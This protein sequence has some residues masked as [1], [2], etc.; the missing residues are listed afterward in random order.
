M[1]TLRIKTSSPFLQGHN[2]VFWMAL[3][4]LLLRLSYVLVVEPSPSF[5]GGDA[6]WYMMNGRDLVTTGKTAGPL[7]TGPVY[8]VFVGM[9]QVLVPGQSSSDLREYTH[10]E[11]QTAR[12]FQSFLSAALCVFAYV[13]ARRAVGQR[14]ARLAAGILVISPAL[15][16]DAG[17]LTTEA[18]FMFL[19]FGGLAC[20]AG[21]TVTPRRLA[22]AGLI[23]GLASLTRPVFLLFPFGI[24]I[25]LWL[26]PRAHRG[27]LALALL[28]SYGLIVST[29]T[30]YNLLVWDRFIVGGEGFLSFVHQGITGQ[31]SPE[32]ADESLD[33]S[34]ETSHEQRNEALRE[35]IEESIRHDPV[36]WAAH[37]VKEL[38]KAY[39]QPHNTVRFK[40][41]SIQQMASKWLRK[42]RSLDGLI[43]LT[44][45]QSF[46]PKLLLY[47]FHYSGLLLGGGGMWLN[48][49]RWRPLLPLYG[50]I[51]YF[52]GIHLILL[53]LPRYLFPT[54]PVF[55][56]FAASF[57]LAV[58][59]WWSR[60]RLRKLAAVPSA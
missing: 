58:W 9:V 16:L 42:D 33:I 25:H 31:V 36:G 20:Y 12:V 17:N 11:M 49:R 35:E 38:G 48:W 18:V 21:A 28:A 5:R 44:H 59:E 1:P 27:R 53:A 2:P 7:Q 40:G 56:I 60:W 15:I 10:L 37:R 13:L 19:V 57:I 54:Y 34:P 6:N 4:A 51:L 23:F 8:L 26:T 39:L 32:Q 22:A 47:L 30:A 45:M 3:A 50:M 29:W 24:A 14:A 43:D 55:W 52:T 41:K 46:W